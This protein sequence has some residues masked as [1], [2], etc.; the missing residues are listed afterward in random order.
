MTRLVLQHYSGEPGEVERRSI[1]NIQAYAAKEG[2]AYRFLDGAVF[3]DR[4]S[5]P[6]QK[7]IILDP[8][9]DDFD[10]VVMLDTDMFTRV[11]MTESLFDQDGI[12]VSGASQRRLKWAFIRKRKGLLHWRYPY[13][14]GSV[15]KLTLA[16]RKRFRQHLPKVDLAKYSNGRLE[17]EGVMHQLARHAKFRGGI[18]PGEMRWSWDSYRPGIEEAALIHIRPKIAPKGPE[19]PK[20]ETLNA[21]VDRG[22][23]AP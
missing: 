9:F 3:D 11:G 2:A 1:R 8:Q 4:L 20:I 10:T 23:I 12:G 5:A 15:W 19:R 18:L 13:W 21:L 14:S 6:M 17:D 7:L 22:L 16:E